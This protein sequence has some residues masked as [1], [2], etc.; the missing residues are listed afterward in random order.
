MPLFEIIPF[1]ISGI[2]H[3][4]ILLG[5]IEE[6]EFVV[7]LNDDVSLFKIGRASL[8]CLTFIGGNFMIVPS[9]TG[10]AFT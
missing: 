3:K 8:H 7:F 2:V 10:F 6:N 4:R 1:E 5:P 9:V